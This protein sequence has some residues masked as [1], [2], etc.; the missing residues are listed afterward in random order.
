MKQRQDK[1]RGFTLVELLMAVWVMSIILAAVATLS[2]AL[3][4]ANDAADNTSEI[5]SR[6]RYTTVRVSELARSGKLICSNSGTSVAIWRAD[7]NGDSRINPGEIVYLEAGNG[8][9][10]INIVTFLGTGAA[11]SSAL[12]L[13]DIAGG[14][15]RTWLAANTQANSITLINNCSTVSFTTD[16]TPPFA[17]Q[18][19][20]F[21]GINQNGS[22]KNYQITDK[23][24]CYADYLLDDSGQIKPM[25]DDI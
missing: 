13:A 12:T 11:A 22:V 23:L 17:K 21:F 25:D 20:I 5:Y 7:D 15:A 8:N 3:G 19:N 4:S 9:N 6:I 16:Q 18:L 1:C 10:C 24:R 14:Q 2:F